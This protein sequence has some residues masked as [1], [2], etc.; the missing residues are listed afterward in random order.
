MALDDKGK[1]LHGRLDFFDRNI[2]QFA[3]HMRQIVGHHR[4]KYPNLKIRGMR[5]RTY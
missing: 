3:K 4:G 5:F 2:T 1:R